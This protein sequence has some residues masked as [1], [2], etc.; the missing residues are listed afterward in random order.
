MLFD[1]DLK[2]EI[3]RLLADS[4]PLPAND[5]HSE[6]SKKKQ[7]SYKY[8]YKTI[9]KLVHDGFLIKNERKYAISKEYI[10]N[11]KK[12]TDKVSKNYEIDQN[13]FMTTFNS[14]ILDLLPDDTKERLH[15]DMSEILR[16]GVMEKLDEWYSEYYD[17]ENA[18]FKKINEEAKL[19]G[20]K[21]LEL[22][23]GTG[24]ISF[25]IAR[26]AKQLTVIDNDKDYLGFC[27]EKSKNLGLNNIKYQQC[28]IKNLKP[29]KEKFDIIV[30]GWAGLHY[31]KNKKNIIKEF[32]RLL[33]PQG[34]LIVIE[35]YIES[36]Y[37]HILNVLH[38]K[39]H[40]KI[41]NKQKEFKD[42]LFR[43][44]GNVREEL[45]NSYYIFPNYEK[46]E[47]TFKI[48]LLYEENVRWTPAMTKRLRNFLKKLPDP[49]KISEPPLFFIVNSPD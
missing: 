32:R 28:N 17:P 39:D 25:Q 43:E 18:E 44:F 11:L 42:I 22:G 29:I 23:C 48:E 4:F 45:V 19:K 16:K 49:L 5:I 15:N 47:E 36:D 41:A 20:K 31:A 38:E 40:S 10:E 12:F 6:I 1:N 9:Q 37:M 21:V 27:K 34:K 46:L 2:E 14:A 35:A 7:Y 3:F 30:S 13:V 26:F 24:R 33:K 8:V